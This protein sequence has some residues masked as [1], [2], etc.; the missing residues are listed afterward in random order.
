MLWA[1]RR[2]LRAGWSFAQPTP[3]FAPNAG[4]VAVYAWAVDGV[5]VGG[6]VVQLHP[7]DF[8]GGWVTSNLR[9]PTQGGPGTQ[10]W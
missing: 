9:G 10:G 4:F 1:G 8:S 2:R 5:F 7:G 3:E 6:E